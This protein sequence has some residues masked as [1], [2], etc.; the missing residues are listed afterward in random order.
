[1][2]GVTTHPT[3]KEELDRKAFETV[4][5]LFTAL[6]RG[7]L[8]PAQF[9]TGIDTLFMA[10]NG[11]V[12]ENVTDLITAA[13]EDARGEIACV[14]Y[15]LLKDNKAVSIVWRVGEDD[16]EVVGYSNGVESTR[17]TKTLPGPKEARAAM[18]RAAET[19]IANGYIQL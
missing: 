8:T 18:Q 7:K 2:S 1:M 10:V 16:I 11:L 6:D 17:Q 4:E 13:D 15:T 19:L 9:S 3:L 12:A 14:R 5:W